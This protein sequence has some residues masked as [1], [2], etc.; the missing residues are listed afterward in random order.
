MPEDMNN[1]G[2]ASL[3]LMYDFKN[4]ARVYSPMFLLKDSPKFRGSY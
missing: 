2:I 3:D 1:T 4:S